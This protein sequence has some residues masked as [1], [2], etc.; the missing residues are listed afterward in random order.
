MAG[1]TLTASAPDYD[2]HT[3]GPSDTVAAHRFTSICARLPLESSLPAPD[4]F[5]LISTNAHRD[6]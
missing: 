6:A 3:P 5:M 1:D 2:W 4:S